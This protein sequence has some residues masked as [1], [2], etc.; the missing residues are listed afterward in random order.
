MFQ[1]L[2]FLAVQYTLD[3]PLQGTGKAALIAGGAVRPLPWSSRTW[4]LARRNTQRINKLDQLKTHKKK[5]GWGAGVCVWREEGGK[6]SRNSSKRKEWSCGIPVTPKKPFS[7]CWRAVWLPPPGIRKLPEDLAKIARSIMQ[8]HLS[9]MVA[10]RIRQL[11]HSYEKR[12]IRMS[13]YL[14]WMLYSSK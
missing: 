4:E 6:R 13:Y 14:L 8:S 9:Q 10:Y 2:P 7:F 11:N 5:G 12:R 1:F 3:F